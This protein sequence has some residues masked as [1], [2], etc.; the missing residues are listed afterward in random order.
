MD[1]ELF[2]DLV[3]SLKD[4]KDFQDGK[5]ELSG[6]IRKRVKFKDTEKFDSKKVK[7]IRL[8]LHLSQT[9][10]A[11]ALGTS[12]K[13]VQAWEAER[14][15]PKGPAARLLSLLKSNPDYINSL[16]VQ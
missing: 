12:V 7:E 14:N 5:I 4:V 9:A 11:D 15:T 2:N 8:D 16:V 10:F 6:S 1:K 13:T 3:S